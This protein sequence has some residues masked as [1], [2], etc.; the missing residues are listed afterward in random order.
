MKHCFSARSQKFVILTVGLLLVSTVCPTW[1]QRAAPIM[2]PAQTK[3]GGVV[4]ENMTLGLREIVQNYQTAQAGNTNA[5]SHNQVQ[6]ILADFDLARSDDQDRVIVDVY[7]DG[8]VS[9]N[10]AVAS[11]EAMGCTVVAKLDWYRNGVYSAWLPLNQAVGLATAR[12][13]STVQLSLKPKHNVGKCTAQGNVVEKAEAIQNT[14][15]YFGASG[16]G[17]AAIMVGAMSDS[18]SM[19]KTTGTGTAAAP[20]Y[21]VDLAPQDIASGDLPGPGNP[22]GNTQAVNVIKDFSSSTVEDE[23]RGMLQIIHDMVPKANL[24]FYTADVSEVDFAV[25]IVALKN[26]GCNVECDDVGYFDEPMF[27]DGP[28]GQAIDQVAA[29]GVSYFSSAGNDDCAGY[30]SDFHPV[31]NNAANQAVLT[32]QGVP[33][34]NI[35]AGEQAVITDFHSFGTAANGDPILVQNVRI[36]GTSADATGRLAF[37][38]DD[39]YNLTVGGVKQVTTDFDIILF[40]STG[41]IQATR[42]GQTNNITGNTPLE[43]PGTAMAAATTYKI[44][45]VRTNRSTAV[46]AGVTPNQA[47]HLRY[48]VDTNDT[49]IHG[50]FLTPSNVNTHGHNDAAGCSGTAAYRYDCSPVADVHDST[51]VINTVVEAFSSNGPVVKYFDAAGN[52][53]AT[54]VVRKQPVLAGVDGVDTSFFPPVGVT[55]GTTPGPTPGPGNPSANDADGDTYPN[56]FGT[57]AAAPNA[58]GVAA[59]VLDAAQANNKTLTPQDVRSLLTTTTQTLTSDSDPNIANATAGP[60]TLTATGF[61]RAD[62]NFFQVKFNGAPGQTL[63]SITIDVSQVAIHWDTTFALPTDTSTTA[64]ATGVVVSTFNGTTG[65]P[66]PS[67]ASFSVANGA[68]ATA[69]SLLTVNFSNFNPGSTLKFGVGRRNDVTNIYGYMTDPLGRT[70]TLSGPQSATITATVAGD[71]GSPY[72]GTMTNTY[73][74]KWNYKTGYGLVDAQAAVNK[75]LAP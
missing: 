14:T 47:T 8:S 46:G 69:N 53:L 10:D 74:R 34:A 26:A 66:A 68:A 70:I 38:W 40:S 9:L 21:P 7:L 59:I 41:A 16:P 2:P 54:P 57:S 49:P 1:A 58:A 37:Q 12:G 63:S 6:T 30:T 44:V 72:S 33:Y 55:S 20:L 19:L 39:P 48:T 51:H 71:A 60:V 13:I 31:T 25:G 56:F 43:L 28:V 75:L 42:S 5:L 50:D 45:I 64:T 73:Q 32:S 3:K 24:A 52:R 65:T 35:T 67:V 4:P 27:S 15:G 62:N 22:L 23:G 61:G 11:A 18:Y 36:P 29:A 17:G